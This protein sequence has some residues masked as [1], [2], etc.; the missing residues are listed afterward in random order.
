MQNLG[1]HGEIFDVR[2]DIGEMVRLFCLSATGEDGDY[3]GVSFPS[4]G[5][6][7]LHEEIQRLFPKLA[8]DAIDIMALEAWKPR[9]QER[10]IR[11]LSVV[12]GQLLDDTRQTVT[13]L[14][15]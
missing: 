6:G 8:K 2:L 13:E 9:D 15:S 1:Q 10:V 11:E 3:G 12:F 14:A 7:R 5:T 4:R